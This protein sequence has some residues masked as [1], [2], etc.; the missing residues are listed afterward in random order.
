MNNNSKKRLSKALAA[1]GVASRRACEQLIFDG[2]V[3]VNGEV[4]LVPQTL[5]SWEEDEILVDGKPVS[6]EESKVY[7]AINKPKGYVCTN[8][9]LS[10]RMKLVIDL[11]DEDRR[12]FTVGRLDKETEGLILVTNDGHFAQKLIHPSQN[13][14]KEYVAKTD[15]EINPQI[16]EK[17][18]NGT[19][20]EG[21][22]VKPTKVEKVRK[23]TVKVTVSEGKKHEVRMLLENA[24]LNVQNLKR[25]RIGHITLGDIAVGNYRNLSQSEIE[26]VFNS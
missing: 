16:L 3:S 8:K 4:T 14:Q 9:R 15:R 1:A 13:I 22:F 6:E 19:V 23:G 21:V 11:F 26:G 7:F 17:I 18:S 20:V 25:I 5:V 12:L 24:G 10:K 2:R